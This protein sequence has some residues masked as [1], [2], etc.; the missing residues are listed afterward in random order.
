MKMKKGKI[1]VTKEMID[2]L[3]RLKKEM[4]IKIDTTVKEGDCLG[5]LYG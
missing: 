3:N 4:K 2:D 5:Y 1:I